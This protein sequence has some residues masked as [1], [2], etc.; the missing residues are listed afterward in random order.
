MTMSEEQL[1]HTIIRM[2]TPILQLEGE[3]Y[4]FIVL[5]FSSWCTNFR[6][7]LITPLFIE[8]DR[9]FG[10]HN[11]YSFTHH[12]PLISVLLFQDRFTPPRQ[13]SQGDPLNGSRCYHGPEA[14]LEGLR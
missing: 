6:Y 11:V 7:E 9:L 13:G 14:W 12:F 8:L 1:T 2:N 4:V 5:D 3:T 10:L